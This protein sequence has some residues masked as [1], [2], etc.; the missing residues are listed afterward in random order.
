[1]INDDDVSTNDVS[2]YSTIVDEGE[3]AW[4]RLWKLKKL[5]CRPGIAYVLYRYGRQVL[6]VQPEE[7]Q[8]ASQ[9]IKTRFTNLAAVDVRPYDLTFEGLL[10]CRGGA[11]EFGIIIRLTCQVSDPSEILNSNIRDAGARLQ[12][13]IFERI[14]RVRHE[15][16]VD[17]VVRVQAAIAAILD[18]LSDRLPKLEPAFKVT[19]LSVEVKIDQNLRRL[20]N[21][22][23]AR[24]YAESVVRKGAIGIAA[25]QLA[26]NAKDPNAAVKILQND[27]RDL[28]QLRREE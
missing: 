21:I 25:Y 12:R 14:S 9:I 20:L 23:L 18:D 11:H 26:S 17:D 15:H 13:T 8:S 16:G 22:E 10:P 2:T 28:V 24:E 27:R 6:V 5:L 1:M 7:Q 19:K 3:L 4:Y